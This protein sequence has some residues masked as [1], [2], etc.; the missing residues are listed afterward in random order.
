MTVLVR[1]VLAI[2][3]GPWAAAALV[4]P[5]A[6]N[7]QSW[8]HSVGGPISQATPTDATGY[9]HPEWLAEPDWLEAHLDDPDVRVVAL[10]PADEFAGGHIPGAAQIDWPDL[11]VVD[12]ADPSIARWQGEVEQ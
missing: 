7:V 9:A 4:Q 5:G 2:L 8:A 1:L 6:D 12:T 10:T 3:L 11:E